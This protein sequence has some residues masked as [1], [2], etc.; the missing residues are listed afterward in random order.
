[1]VIVLQQSLNTHTYTYGHKLLKFWILFIN[2]YFCC[3]IL[4][5]VKAL[6]HLWIER[7]KLS[8]VHPVMSSF[9]LSPASHSIAV[10]AR[11]TRSKDIGTPEAIVENQWIISSKLKDQK[12][13]SNFLECILFGSIRSSRSHFVRES[14]RLVQ[15]CQELSI[16]IIL[17]QVS[18]RSLFIAL[19]P[20]LV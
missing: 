14:V 10:V 3:Q 16:F 17:A 8:Y 9:G 4:T 19:W 13:L 15:V 18:L 20:I 6:K 7:I 2:H 1:M 12:N 5:T 11:L